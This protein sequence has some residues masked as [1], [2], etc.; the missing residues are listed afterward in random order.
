[1]IDDETL[2]I[3]TESCDGCGLCAPACP[4][5]AISSHQALPVLSE[6]GT[7]ALFACENAGI[8]GKDGVIPCLHTLGL[9]ELLR[10]Y[11]SDTRCICVA[12]GDCESCI[13]ND[14]LQLPDLLEQLNG[15]LESRSLDTI[16]LQVTDRKQWSQQA[17]K[18]Q[19]SFKGPVLS[20][21]AFF[22]KA[23]TSSITV[24]MD[25]A[26]VVEEQAFIPPGKILPRTG[27]NEVVPVI[28]RI[29][30]EKCNGCNACARLCP[31]DAIVLC[32]DGDNPRYLLDAENCT[33]CAMC[34]DIC[35][36][37]A[38]S[39]DRWRSQVQF[40][41]PLTARRCRTCGAPFHLP[42]V[43]ADSGDLC[44]VCLQTN[45]ARNLYQVME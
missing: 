5:G 34:S 10:L 40:M 16:T 41:L 25:L 22:R 39:I 31:Q 45:H 37:K 20:R 19:Q 42:A 28:P 3:N 24:G 9:Q 8:N 23:A 7:V 11:R 38:V 30:P 33:G 15:L 2:G 29:D 17:Q 36:Q 1:M 14:V 35:N 21:R 18:A 44:V 13:R 26:G 32:N 6:N 27:R 12:R 43:K 4:Q